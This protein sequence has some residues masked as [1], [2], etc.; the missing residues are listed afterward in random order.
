MKEVLCKKYFG[1]NKGLVN[2][3]FDR[4]FNFVNLV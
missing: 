4:I 1:L 2:C 3:C